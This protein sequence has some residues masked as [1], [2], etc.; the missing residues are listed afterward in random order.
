M[1]ATRD[2]VIEQLTR[3]ATRIAAELRNRRASRENKPLPIWYIDSIVGSK[4]DTIGFEVRIVRSLS[5]LFYALVR[6]DLS[7]D[8]YCSSRKRDSRTITR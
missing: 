7:R 4:V 5:A 6:P 1:R 2:Q 3:Y 8:A